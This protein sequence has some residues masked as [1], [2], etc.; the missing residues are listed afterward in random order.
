MS[1]EKKTLKNAESSYF[2]TVKTRKKHLGIMENVPF[3]SYK[4]T[5]IFISTHQ[6][7]NRRRK[8]KR[9]AAFVEVAVDRGDG[10]ERGGAGAEPEP[11]QQPEK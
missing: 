10:G 3:S 8:M 7:R 1:R 2:H 4:Y 9:W 11:V 5:I 6:I